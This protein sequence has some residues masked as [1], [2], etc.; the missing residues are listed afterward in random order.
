[1]QMK[2]SLEAAIAE[3][4]SALLEFKRAALLA[5]LEGRQVKVWTRARGQGQCFLAL[6][7]NSM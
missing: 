4:E 5:V 7:H 3:M 1:M 2:V 6:G